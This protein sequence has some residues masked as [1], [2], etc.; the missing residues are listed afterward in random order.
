[1][2]LKQIK[3]KHWWR[4]LLVLVV[5]LFAGRDVVQAEIQFSSAPTNISWLERT[6]SAWSAR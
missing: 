2:N 1:M 4:E 3:L 5:C 6:Q